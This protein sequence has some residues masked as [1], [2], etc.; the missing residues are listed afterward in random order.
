MDFKRRCLATGAPF[1]HALSFVSRWLNGSNI[2][3]NVWIGT[4]CE[5]QEMADKRIPEL[6]KIP[7]KVRFLSL[8]PLLEEIDLGSGEYHC[9]SG[10]GSE[11]KPG[12]GTQGVIGP[13]VDWVIVGGES[14]K[15]ARPCNVAWIRSIVD[16]CKSAGVPCFVKQ[17]RRIAG[18]HRK[19][20]V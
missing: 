20:R 14:G 2:P 4:S 3:R 7:A 9:L 6:L 13:K 10:C 19:L 12:F 18:S 8:E 16:Q 1:D 5:N 17:R 11:E 15:K